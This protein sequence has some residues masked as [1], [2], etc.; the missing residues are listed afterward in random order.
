M[1]LSVQQLP[2]NRCRNTTTAMSAINTFLAAV[3]VA[4]GL[5]GVVPQAHGRAYGNLTAV[6]AR[7]DG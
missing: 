3:L 1:L 5:L 7:F 6:D 4:G 2:L